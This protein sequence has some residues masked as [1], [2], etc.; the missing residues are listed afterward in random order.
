MKDSNALPNTSQLSEAKRALLEK[1]LRADTPQPVKA[2]RAG[3]VTPIQGCE[4]IEKRS[5]S[6]VDGSYEDAAL[7][8]DANSRSPLIAVQREGSRRPFFYMHV[9]WEG[10]AFYCFT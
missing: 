4:S 7:L 2:D 10:G 8:T 9:H 6:I 3:I 1:Y 5:T